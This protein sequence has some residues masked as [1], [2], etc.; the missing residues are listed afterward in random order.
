MFKKPYNYLLLIN[1]YIKKEEY[2]SF[3]LN[4]GCSIFDIDGFICVCELL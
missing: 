2:E 4:N 3:T 1:Y